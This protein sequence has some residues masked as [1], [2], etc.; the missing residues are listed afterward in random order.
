ML[1]KKPHFYLLFYEGCCENQMRQYVEKYIL[2]LKKNTILNDINILY[3]HI[4]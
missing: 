1:A 4:Q 3:V 2:T